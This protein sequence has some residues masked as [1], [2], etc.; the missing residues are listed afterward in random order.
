MVLVGANMPTITIRNANEEVGKKWALSKDRA[1]TYSI[2]N[3]PQALSEIQVLK[4]SLD[5][6]DIWRLQNPDS[7]RYTWRREQQASHIDYYLISF[8][9]TNNTQGIKMYHRGPINIRSCYCN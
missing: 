2:N 3:H 1:G 9:L 4:A 7:N 6:V 5:L 8:S